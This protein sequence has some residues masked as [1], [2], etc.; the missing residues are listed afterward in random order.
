MS[1]K[2]LA[3]NIVYLANSRRAP[4]P[5]K[6]CIDNLCLDP[7][8]ALAIVLDCDKFH[9]FSSTRHLAAKHI[10]I[11]LEQWATALGSRKVHSLHINQPQRLL[12][13]FEL[14]KVMY[15]LAS[16]F[17]VTPQSQ[18]AQSVISYL[19]DINGEH[20]ALIKGLGFTTYHIIVNPEELADKA[21]LAKK[22]ATLRDY[23]MHTIGIQLLNTHNL[24]D[25]RASVQEI[26]RHCGPE[27]IYTGAPWNRSDVYTK[28]QYD[29][30]DSET[31]SDAI[32]R[33]ELGPEGTH[34]LGD[35]TLSNYSSPVKYEHALAIK[36]LPIHLKY[37][38]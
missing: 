34:R 23:A 15:L 16:K 20:L 17:R 21:R 35:E 4:S 19:D 3:P 31:H 6:V 2:Y 10:V 26:R 22:I 5:A 33:V 29:S 28:D 36:R 27:F 9:A 30:T 38:F 32:D 1:K 25:M 37:Q 8:R 12:K 14:T 7:S 13:S 24:A 18:G 11:E